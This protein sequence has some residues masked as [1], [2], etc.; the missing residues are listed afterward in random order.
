MKWAYPL[1][2]IQ[3]ARSSYYYN[4]VYIYNNV[5]LLD[6]EI[7]PSD[8]NHFV[9]N[10]AQPPFWGIIQDLTWSSFIPQYMKDMLNPILMIHFYHPLIA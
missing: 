7:P 10:L 9:K 1:N 5:L 4:N 8:L 2:V 3:Y 6:K